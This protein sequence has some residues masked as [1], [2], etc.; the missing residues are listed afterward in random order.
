MAFITLDLIINT[1]WFLYDAIIFSSEWSIFVVLVMAAVNAIRIIISRLFDAVILLFISIVLK[2]V[3]TCY[4]RSGDESY[5]DMGGFSYTARLIWDSLF[6]YETSLYVLIIITIYNL[7][8]MIYVHIV[9]ALFLWIVFF[10]SFVILKSI[11]GHTPWTITEI[12]TKY[13]N[14]T[15]YQYLPY[16]FN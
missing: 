9:H 6:T 7:V 16:F 4:E 10:C 1:M 8:Y 15:V 3:F 14:D 12:G 11:Y 5:N 2:I 13:S